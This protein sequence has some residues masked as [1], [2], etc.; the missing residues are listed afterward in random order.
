M[1]PRN[2]QHAESEARHLIGAADINEDNKLSLKEILDNY[3]V[4]V[5]SKLYNYGRNVH[6]EF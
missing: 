2:K 3:F 6:D 5:G 1:N 4:F